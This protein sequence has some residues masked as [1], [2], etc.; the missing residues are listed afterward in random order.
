MIST[1]YAVDLASEISYYVTSR[2][3][4]TTTVFLQSTPS[5]IEELL[6]A[7][8]QLSKGILN[9]PSFEN[10]RA[11]V[12]RQLPTDPG[13]GDDVTRTILNQL[14]PRNADEFKDDSHKYRALASKID[15]IKGNYLSNWQAEFTKADYM[16]APTSGQASIIP[17]PDAAAFI[18]TFLL[19][20][21]L[22]SEYL[23]KWVSYRLLQASPA[24]TLSD[25]MQ[26]LIHQYETGYGR[27]E[28][29]VVL[30][31]SA[32]PIARAVDGW[33]SRREVDLWFQQNGFTPPKGVHGGILYV[34]DQWDIYGALQDVSSALRRISYRTSLKFDKSP[35]F[36]RL[37][38]IK[39]VE[40]PRRIPSLSK[41][42]ARIS[43]YQMEAPSLVSP[44]SDNRLEVTIEFL[45]AASTVGGA[46]AA[47]MLWAAVETLLAAPGDPNK[48]EA[49]QRGANI[50][51][52]VF[53]RSNVLSAIGIL[54]GACKDEQLGQEISAAQYSDRPSRLES[55]LKSREFESL[56]NASVRT[57]L[58]HTANLLN[59]AYVDRLN[60]SF[61][62]CLDGLYRQRN[63]VLHGGVTDGPLLESYL[64]CGFP[65]V[66]GIVNQYG[67]A[68]EKS[69]TDPQ[70][71][72]FQA[73]A[74]IESY[75]LRASSN[76][77][78]FLH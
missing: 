9:A 57:Y 43:G 70:V 5:L 64:R 10:V 19:A 4:W 50:D 8:I 73:Y 77:V 40:S 53:I 29:M 46:A 15:E 20:A 31:Q 35:V 48:M 65:L 36:N 30:D 44:T 61:R 45:Q 21:G 34:A 52:V 60:H 42:Q 14:V 69:L 55:A 58:G 75:K 37:A 71:V 59:K 11:Q 39:G 18:T 24:I 28:I 66:A 2:L 41:F 74:S 22:S 76:I 38:W 16:A 78:D 56:A 23:S 6:L 63:M 3:G 1:P 54:M 62:Q 13:M 32:A 51:L 25:F 27:S 12:A 67:R 68:N 26:Q 7:R 72:A 33:L 17:A 47:G 49:V